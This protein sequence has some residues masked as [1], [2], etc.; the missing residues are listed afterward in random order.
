MRRKV[1]S[2]DLVYLMGPAPTFI[3]A[4]FVLLSLERKRPPV[5]YTHQ[6]VH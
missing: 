3:D 6:F 2:A 4:F 1:Q 5:I